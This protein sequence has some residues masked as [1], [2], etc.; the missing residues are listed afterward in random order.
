M[1]KRG[2]GNNPFKADSTN[3]ILSPTNL[4]AVDVEHSI[5]Y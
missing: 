4:T 3:S 5:N 1:S 2:L